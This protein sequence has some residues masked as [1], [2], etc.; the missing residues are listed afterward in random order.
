MEFDD[1][2][3]VFFQTC[4]GEL[5]GL[6]AGERNFGFRGQAYMID[7]KNRLFCAINY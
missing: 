2:Q 6:V 3:K 4:P 1:G 5:T 7:V